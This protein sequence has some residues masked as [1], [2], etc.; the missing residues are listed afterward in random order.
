M[1][2]KTAIVFGWLALA[3]AAF[4]AIGCTLANPARD[5]K[6]LYPEMTSYRE[7]VK[8]LAKLPDGRAAYEALRA[9]VGG[10]LDPSVGCAGV[11]RYAP[12]SSMSTPA[13]ISATPPAIRPVNGSPK[14]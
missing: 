10:D 8:E 9:R 6:A 3:P 12:Y 7:D 4:G 2:K 13:P 5:L 1:Q 11:H 14:R